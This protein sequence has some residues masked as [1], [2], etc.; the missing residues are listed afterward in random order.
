M[1]PF[2]FGSSERS[3]F[4]VYHPSQASRQRSSGIVLC[5]ATRDEY[6]LSHRAFR[7][8]ATRLARLGFP[9][10]RFD[11]YGSGDSFGESHEGTVEQ[12]KGD[13][14]R[15]IDE[16]KGISGVA[17]VSLIGLRLGAT[18]AAMVASDRRDIGDLENVVLWDPVVFG[19]R[20]LDRLRARHQ[21]FLHDRSQLDGAG[22]DADERDGVLGL[23]L[24]AEL[25]AD[26]V[27]IDLTALRG[28][29]GHRV[30]MVVCER[31]PE[32]EE[33]IRHLKE[34]GTDLVC[35]HI[36]GWR[37][38]EQDVLWSRELVPTGVIQR[39]ASWLE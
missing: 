12:W 29:P 21:Q 4:G 30:F 2:H 19:S 17:R 24:T 7:Q 35:E 20:Y 13:I 9:S 15:A 11:Y 25:C 6:F 8:L 26:L 16:L 33:L 23:P 27:S 37:I 22:A 28:H 38:W 34:A 5:H 3:L 10:L 32:C 18:L 31:S 36:P 1:N 14:A 39:I